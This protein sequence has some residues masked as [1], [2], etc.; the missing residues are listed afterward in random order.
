VDEATGHDLVR[1]GLQPLRSAGEL[2]V[3]ATDCLENNLAA[4]SSDDFTVAVV[5]QGFWYLLRAESC[6]GNGSYNTGSSK[7]IGSRD[8]EI[9]A[10]G[11]ACP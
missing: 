9:A 6:G 4:T 2:H 3:A 8:A 7:Q 5:G 10:S 1:G 11:H